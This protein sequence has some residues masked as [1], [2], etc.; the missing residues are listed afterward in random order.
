MLPSTYLALA[1]TCLSSALAQSAGCGA[2][3]PSSGTRSL[4]VNGQT[5]QYILDVPANYNP[6]Q[7][8][9]LVFGYHWLGGNMNA[10]APGFY[11]LKSLAAGSTIFVAPNGLNNGWANTNNQDLAFTDAIVDVVTREMCVDESQI[12]ATGFSYGGAM[13]YALACS[14]SDVFAAVAVIAGAELSGCVG[15][16]TPTPYLGIHGVV[17]SVLNISLGRGLRDRFLRLNG[18]TGQEAAPPAAGS[19]RHVKTTYTCTGPPVTWIA[20]SGDHIGD[21]AFAPQETWDF[22]NAV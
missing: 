5:R 19:G 3:V 12:F 6:N 2:G 21:P 10:V 8:H 18:C 1:A 20:H 4:T 22:F 17:D 13:S 15:G 7:P 9:R 14:R 11:G 16:T